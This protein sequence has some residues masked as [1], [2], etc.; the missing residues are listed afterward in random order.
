MPG[1]YAFTATVDGRSSVLKSL[2]DIEPAPSMPGAFCRFGAIWDTGATHSSIT[3]EVVDRCGLKP[4]G[5]VKVAHAGIDD[6]PDETDLYMVNIRLPNQ[7]TV[8]NVPVSRGGF[9]GGDVL[10]GMDIINTGDFAITHAKGQTKFTFQIP[11]QADIDFVQAQ[12]LPPPQNRE[13]RRA[14][15]RMKR[16]R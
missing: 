15:N 9:S 11:P 4:I 16:R 13:E 12:P 7:V 3:Q 14:R 5:K 6:E 10:I 1:S 2:C 8:A